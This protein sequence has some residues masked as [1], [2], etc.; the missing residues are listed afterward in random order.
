MTDQLPESR[1]TGNNIQLPCPC[2]KHVVYYPVQ[3]VHM[4]MNR[5]YT[6][7]HTMC[8]CGQAYI[9]VCQDNG[10]HFRIQRRAQKLSFHLS[11]P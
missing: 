11:P 3:L 6:V 2:N 9:V 1:L 5:Q 10:A 4:A 8:E 7:F